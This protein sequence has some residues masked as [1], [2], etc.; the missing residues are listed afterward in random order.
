MSDAQCLTLESDALNLPI[1]KTLSDHA[2]ANTC[3]DPS[4]LPSRLNEEFYTQRIQPRLRVS[5]FGK[6]RRLCTYRSRTLRLFEVGDATHI[7]DTGRRWRD[8]RA[9]QSLPRTSWIKLI[10]IAR[11][12]KTCAKPPIVCFV[13]KARIQIM[14]RVTAMSFRTGFPPSRRASNLGRRPIMS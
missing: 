4:S 6:Y 13:T 5:R 12:S 1:F 9:H 7:R 2:V 14:K 11:T 10:T 3:W 8:S